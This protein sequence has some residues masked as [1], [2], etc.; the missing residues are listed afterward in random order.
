MAESDRFWAQAPRDGGYKTLLNELTS[1]EAKQGGRP[2][3]T[4]HTVNFYDIADLG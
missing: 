1:M 4:Q 3:L 2:F